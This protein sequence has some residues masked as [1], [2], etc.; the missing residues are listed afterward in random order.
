MPFTNI[1]PLLSGAIVWFL[2]AGRIPVVISPESLGHGFRAVATNQIEDLVTWPQ[3]PIIK[4]RNYFWIK[5]SVGEPS[6]N[7]QK[8]QK[9]NHINVSVLD[10]KAPSKKVRCHRTLNLLFTELAPRPIQSICCDVCGSKSCHRASIL[11]A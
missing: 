3:T 6:I 1:Q 9:K 11:N 5:L 7:N 4:E 2:P 10:Q 8:Y